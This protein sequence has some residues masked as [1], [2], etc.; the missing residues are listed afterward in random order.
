MNDELAWKLDAAVIEWLFILATLIILT[1]AGA[2]ATGKA[3]LFFYLQ[4][5]IKIV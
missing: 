5:S 3:G 2:I 4:K 1:V